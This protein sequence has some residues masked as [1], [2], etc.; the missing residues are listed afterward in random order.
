MFG[1]SSKKATTTPQSALCRDQLS[2]KGGS[3]SGLMHYPPNPKNHDRDSIYFDKSEGGGQSTSGATG[4]ITSYFGPRQQAASRKQVYW[5]KVAEM[6][7]LVLLPL[8]FPT[9][10]GFRR[11]MHFAN[12]GMLI[13]IHTYCFIFWNACNYLDKRQGSFSY[14]DLSIPR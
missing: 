5:Q 7:I 14:D 1:N 10:I 8:S 2:C 11:L 13:I 9:G 12:P 6:A 4:G 3:R